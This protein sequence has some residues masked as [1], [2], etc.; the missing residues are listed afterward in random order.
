MQVAC[1]FLKEKM[2]NSIHTTDYLLSSL[3]HLSIGVTQM[4]S[5]FPSGSLKLVKLGES[6]SVM[7]DSLGPHGL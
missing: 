4:N 6:S 2:P 1:L 3:N 5:K 7:S